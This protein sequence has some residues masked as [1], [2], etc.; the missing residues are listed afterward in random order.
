M[1]FHTGIDCILSRLNSSVVA[2]LLHLK[3]LKC[4]H[5]VAL[6]H[7]GCCD[8]AHA[9][10]ALLCIKYHR[11]M[12]LDTDFHEL[13]LRFHSSLIAYIRLH[14]NIFLLPLHFAG[15]EDVL[16]VEKHKIVY[17]PTFP[18]E[19]GPVISGNTTAYICFSF[20]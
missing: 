6:E 8:V 12:R 3:H 7:F 2:I 9:F 11:W 14:L 19:P 16:P 15:I 10:Y 1:R 17:F 18:S 13:L 20:I 4:L 5:S